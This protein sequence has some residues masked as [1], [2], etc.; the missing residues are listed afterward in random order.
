MIKHIR[1]FCIKKRTV[2]LGY[3]LPELLLKDGS[4]YY[5]PIYISKK[6]VHVLLGLIKEL[7]PLRTC[8]YDF[9]SGKKSI[10]ESTKFA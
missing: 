4:E 5:G 2:F 9:I 8:T 1:G 7:Y 3:F 10:M 6:T